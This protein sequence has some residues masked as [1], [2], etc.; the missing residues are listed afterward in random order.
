M[1]SVKVELGHVVSGGCLQSRLCVASVQVGHQHFAA[2]DRTCAGASTTRVLLLGRCDKGQLK[3]WRGLALFTTL[4]RLRNEA[5]AVDPDDKDG[6][7]LGDVP[8]QKKR[9]RSLKQTVKEQPLRSPV[10]VLVTLGGSY[11]NMVLLSGQARDPVFFEITPQN[12][13]ALQAE[14]LAT[15]VVARPQRQREDI[16]LRPRGKHGSSQDG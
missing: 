15:I 8:P 9:K 11:M 7:N 14:A 10:N 5:S 12:I 16:E 3:L 4:Q 1:G 2:L 13:A 6:L